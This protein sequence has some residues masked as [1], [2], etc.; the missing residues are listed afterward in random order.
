MYGM[1]VKTGSG[2]VDVKPSGKDAQPYRYTTFREADKYL[3]M[4]YPDACLLGDRRKARVINLDPSLDPDV[5]VSKVSI[6]H[7][8][9]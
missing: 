3:R 2:W 7:T 6:I 8:S 5:V 1:Q 4:C 9:E